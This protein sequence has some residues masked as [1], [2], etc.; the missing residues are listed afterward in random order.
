MVTTEELARTDRPKIHRACRPIQGRLATTYL[1]I[2]CGRDNH[3]CHARLLLARAIISLLG[4]MDAEGISDAVSSSPQ[5]R[6]AQDSSEISRPKRAK[7]TNA[8]W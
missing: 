6:A 3:H 4:N 8:A 2:A 1:C 7:Y 5:K